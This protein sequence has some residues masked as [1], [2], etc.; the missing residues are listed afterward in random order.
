MKLT[1]KTILVLLFIFISAHTFAISL[2]SFSRTGAYHSDGSYIWTYTAK[3]TSASTKAENYTAKLNTPS[4]FPFDVIELP[5]TLSADTLK[6]AT[7]EIKISVQAKFITEP[8]NLKSYKLKISLKGENDKTL[9]IDFFTSC[10]LPEHP[11]L[12]IRKNELTDLKRHFAHP[13]FNDIRKVF[14][15]QKNYSTDGKVISDQP[16]ERI[17]Q[18]MEALALEY[19]MDT[20]R[21]KKSGREAI[22]LAINY[23]NS[24]SINRTVKA[25]S[26]EENTNT[27]EA[28]LGGS[29]VYDW[30]YGLLSE[31]EKA[32]LFSGLKKVCMLGEYGLPGSSKVQY[33]AGHYGECAPTA[34]LSIGIA[35]YDEDPSFFDFE[36]N[37]QV[38]KFAPSRNPMYKCN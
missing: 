7:I 9:S 16:D 2:N 32:E 5:S 38:T 24:Y 8:A 1:L 19:L 33:L 35:T 23:M 4:D 11:R 3:V 13:D 31:K 12:F 17:R 10:P 29:I 20:V 30:C 21:N 18:K 15:E 36:Y 37:E 34:F 14:N 26:Y 27:Y 28:I 22:K 6:P 25:V